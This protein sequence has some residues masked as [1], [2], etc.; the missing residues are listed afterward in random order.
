VD[1]E[2]LHHAVDGSGQQLKPGPLLG[3]DQVLG[4]AVRLLLGLGEVVGK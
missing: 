1:R 4:Q 3:L 2:L